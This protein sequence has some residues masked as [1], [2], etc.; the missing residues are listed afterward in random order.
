MATVRGDAREWSERAHR[1]LAEHAFNELRQRILAGDLVSGQ[2]LPI[3]DLAASLGMSVMPVREALRQLEAVGLVQHRPH[4]GATVAEAS[5]E[6]LRDLLRA[7]LL[8]ESSAA[9]LAAE[10][11]TAAANAA[12]EAA[13]AGYD[14][15]LRGRDLAGVRSADQ[16]FHTVI[17]EAAESPWLRRLI[18]PVW[19][20]AA[21]YRRITSP[22]RPEL[23]RRQVEHR[24][25]LAACAGLDGPAAA[26]AMEYHLMRS[27]NAIARLMGMAVL[28]PTVES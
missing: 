19:E 13:L 21:R 12:A 23:Q 14:A 16:A 17:Y 7:R 15:A 6:E 5:A 28:F 4:R 26:A 3:R 24:A 22:P 27:A 18:T 10:R 20:S 25:V 11:F 1:T 8:L 9:E 2:H